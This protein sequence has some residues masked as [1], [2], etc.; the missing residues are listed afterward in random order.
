MPRLTTPFRRLL[1]LLVFA[2]LALPL[3]A[4]Q[5]PPD[6]PKPTE[7]PPTEEPERVLGPQPYDPDR[8]VEPPAGEE[9][10]WGYEAIETSEPDE[11]AETASSVEIVRARPKGE[12][13][14]RWVRSIGRWEPGAAR[15]AWSAQ[16]DRIAFDAPGD[17]GFRAIYVRDAE[18]GQRRCLTC[19]LWQLRK[20]NVL[21]PEWHPSGDWIAV[22]VQDLPR[23]LLP[24][25]ARM[26]SFH[27]ALHADLWILTADGRN[28]WQLTRSAEQGG[29]VHEAKISYEG[30]RIAWTERTDSRAGTEGAWVVRV[31]QL[32][33]RKVPSFKNDRTLRPTTWPSRVVVE[34]FTQN[35]RG[36]WLTLTA[37]DR[38]GSLAARYDLD[39]LRL[40]LLDT[41][42]TWDLEARAVP[43]GE[44]IVLAS[45][46]GLDRGRA[47]PRSA[48]LWFITPLGLRQE[49][50]TFFNDPSSDH[51]L[52]ETLISDIAWAPDGRAVLLSLVSSNGG[53]TE[54]A[55][56]RVDLSAG[57]QGETSTIR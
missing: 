33:L 30:D 46:R 13:G 22:I 27:R 34:G 47:L 45:D 10:V 35:D 44:R 38:V 48:D 6:Q 26:A 25:P 42:G 56:W 41:G 55:L 4:I 3:R 2:L 57:L 37:R 39:T 21:A 23:R 52:G 17:L 51:Y 19:D 20:K 16:G 43:R 31:A 24:S 50:L 32:E 5:D 12:L 9:D 53:T 15:A 11:A 49:R 14:H 40:D 54:E 18:T 28:A 36:L 29:A 8:P 1:P 7:K